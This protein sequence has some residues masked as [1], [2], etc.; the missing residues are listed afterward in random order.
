MLK[1]IDITLKKRLHASEK[2][3]ERVQKLRVEFWLKIQAVPH[4][5]RK[6]YNSFI[7]NNRENL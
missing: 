6:G 5:P 1:K 4:Q 7:L 2:E 3:T